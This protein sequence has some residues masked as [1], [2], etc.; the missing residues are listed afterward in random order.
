MKRPPIERIANVVLA[1]FVPAATALAILTWIIWLSLG[2]SGALPANT[3]ENTVGG[4]RTSF[5]FVFS[6]N[7]LKPQG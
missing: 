4:W 3:L 6:L 1:Y 5:F 2:L 7:Y